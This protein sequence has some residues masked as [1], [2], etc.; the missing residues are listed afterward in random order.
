MR[1]IFK[2]FPAFSILL[3]EAFNAP[4]S[5]RGY[6]SIFSP[7]G[8]REGENLLPDYCRNYPVCNNYSFLIWSAKAK[9]E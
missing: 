9:K 8:G 5:F 7:A 2:Y 1:W 4:P 6:D 3:F